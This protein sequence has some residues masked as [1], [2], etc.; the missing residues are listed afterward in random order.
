[1]VAQPRSI[2]LA[3]LEGAIAPKHRASLL[4][5]LGNK[6]QRLKGDISADK[7][8]EIL[9]RA[10]NVPAT[11][12]GRDNSE[13]ILALIKSDGTQ[14]EL[15]TTLM[16]FLAG[17]LM[18]PAEADSNKELIEEIILGAADKDFCKARASVK[19]LS[20]MPKDLKLGPWSGGDFELLFA[21][22]RSNPAWAADILVQ[23][24]RIAPQLPDEIED[25]EFQSAFMDLIA[26]HN[27]DTT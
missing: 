16:P 2:H 22:T 24:V 23:A 1:L 19:L 6:D 14:E 5:S 3:R 4:R 8:I 12:L 11:S 20:R 10:I 15:L 7:L 18:F 21:L 26:G 25:D 27:L 17:L 9:R 13:H